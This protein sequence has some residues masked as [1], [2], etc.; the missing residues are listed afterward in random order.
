MSYKTI[1][2]HVDD[3][4][5]L[6]PRIELA[7]RIALQE[8]AHL[9]GTATTGIS[10]FIYQSAIVDMTNDYIIGH[11]EILRQRAAGGLERFGAITR[12]AGIASVETRL[13]DE[14]TAGS[15]SLQARYSD[16]VVLGQANPDEPS[17]VVGKDLPEVVAL[18]GGCPVLVVPYVGR[19]DDFGDRVLVA[20]DASL[21]AK[22]AVHDALPLLRRAA[23]VEVAVFNASERRDAHGA[24]PGADIALY[25]ARHGITVNVRESTV[26]H[27]AIGAALLSHVADMDAGM[28]VI[29]CYGHSRLRE[30]M[31]GGVTRTILSSMTVPVLM[32]H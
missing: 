7:C 23:L 11:T 10:A 12:R 21:E 28:L 9:V 30:I 16:L 5:G 26:P 24:Q 25:L 8:E 18:H 20:W 6:A 14:E 29:G 19:F 27:G 22:H 32:S 4:T 1:L 17:A 13:L 15:I 3:A 31:L 2:A